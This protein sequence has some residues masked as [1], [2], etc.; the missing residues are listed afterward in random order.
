MYERRRRGIDLLK[1]F[2]S[3]L[4]STSWTVLVWP[5]IVCS[6]S[7]VSQS[8]ILIVVSSDELATI[9]NVGWKAMP[10]TGMRWPERLY[11]DGLRGIHT[12]GSTFFCLMEDGAESNS[13]CRACIRASRS[14]IWTSANESPSKEK[15]GTDLFLKA[16]HTSPLL[17]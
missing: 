12:N 8:Q 14:M 10:V 3:K 11:R 9:V 15:V 7:P 17:L 2:P 5:L 16:N 1:S 6:N 13:V 4:K